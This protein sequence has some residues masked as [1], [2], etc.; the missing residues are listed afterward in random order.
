[1]LEREHSAILSTFIK[2]PVVSKTLLLSI[3]SGRFTQVLL[4]TF[5]SEEN[6]FERVIG[7]PI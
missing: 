7:I 5:V 6:M 4:Y 1:M 3:L 2:L